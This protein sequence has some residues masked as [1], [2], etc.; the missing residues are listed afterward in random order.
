MSRA[1]IVTI[2]I[3]ALGSAAGSAAAPDRASESAEDGWPTYNKGYDGQRYSRL[4]QIDTRTA[5]TLKRVCVAGLGDD[6]AFQPGPVV[7]KD[8]IYVTTA[9]TTVALQATT[10]KALW[11]HVYQPEQ[12]EV[13]AINRGVAVLGKRVFRGTGDGRI[14]ALDAATGKLLW[15]IKAADPTVG[16]FY[17]SAPIA[18]KNLLFIGIAGSDWGVRGRMLAF[19]V[20]SG[21]E[22]WRWYSIPMGNDEGADSWVPRDAAARGGGAFWT[23]YTLD[24]QSGELFI[25]VANPA[26]DYNTQPDVR[27]GANLYTN[28]MVVLDARTGR[29]K[30]YHQFAPNDHWDYDVGAAPMLFAG[31]G[32]ERRVAVGSKDG[33]IYALDR[34]SREVK[35]RTPVT[36]VWDNTGK[37]PTTEGTHMCPGTLGGV[38]WNGPAL[39]VKNNAIVV[40][41]VDYCMTY[42]STAPVYRKGAGYYGGSVVPDERASGWVTS[43]DAADGKVRWRYEAAAPVVAGVT[44]TAGGVT[45]AADLQGNFLVLG[46]DSGSVLFQQQLAGGIAGG[47]V[48]YA[49]AGKQYVALTSGNLSRSTFSK[50]KGANAKSTPE[51]VIYGLGLAA[52]EPKLVTV[53]ESKMIWEKSAA[54]GA[55]GVASGKAIYSGNCAVCHGTV[56]EGGVGPSLLGAKERLGFD[57]IVDRVTNPLPKM[58]KL[59]LG[60][61]EVKDVAEYVETLK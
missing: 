18:W 29:M 44:P 40:G 8:T 57:T 55:G 46:S 37:R 38:E 56:G 14:L 10:C 49:V 27:E 30:W 9:H 48:T 53:G 16:E 7:V 35:F 22:V 43:V 60:E 41:A 47:I 59:P 21:K 58:P 15:K 33:Y 4:A 1:L 42:K 2:A 54:T 25:P 34:D 61:R 6:G 20:A 31:P 28:S 17:S 13:Y 32:G 24:A 26:P 52:D 39:D 50:M 23:T 51:L 36:T 45:F 19:D 12:D 11:R 5:G 3:L